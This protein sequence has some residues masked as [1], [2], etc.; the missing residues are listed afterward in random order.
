MHISSFCRSC[1]IV[2]KMG[3]STSWLLAFGLNFVMFCNEGFQNT[4]LGDFPTD[5]WSFILPPA[6]IFTV[7][8]LLFVCVC[9]HAHMCP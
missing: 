4:V 8:I 1:Q 6:I 9:V 2:Y 3:L 5:L 7:V